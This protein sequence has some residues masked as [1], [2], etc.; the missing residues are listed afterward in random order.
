MA[1][2]ISS[3]IWRE[4][5]K[6]F[7]MGMSQAYIRKKY[8]LNPGALGNKI[9]RDGWRLSQ[10]QTAILT[11]FKEASEKI[12]ESFH[13][14]NEVQRKEM[15]DRVVTALEDN[16]LIGN[17]RKLLKA[18][19]GLIGRGIKN[20]IYSEA[21]DIKAGVSA[22][23]DIEAISNPQTSQVNIQNNNQNNQQNLETTGI[24]VKFGDE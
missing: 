13:N 16:E 2:R 7:E 15:S 22:I 24:T 23:R 5:K 17:N 12:S 14:A 4:A 19:Q 1:K 3:H 6:D 8:D 10:E 20:G 11:E 9:K 21:K 18:F